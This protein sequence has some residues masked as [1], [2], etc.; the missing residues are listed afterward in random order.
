MEYMVVKSMQMID[1]ISHPSCVFSQVL[2]IISVT[3]SCHPKHSRRCIAIA[4]MYSLNNYRKIDLGGCHS[5]SGYFRGVD[6]VDIGAVMSM[7][8]E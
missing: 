7:V 2:L 6:I 1:S 8:G 3:A 5:V 4:I